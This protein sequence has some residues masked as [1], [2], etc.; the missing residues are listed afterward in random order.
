MSKT[1]NKNKTI[2]IALIIGILLCAF[3]LT[4]IILKFTVLDFF[5]NLTKPYLETAYEEA[6]KLFITLSLLKGTTDVIEGS[7][8]NVN[9]ILGM[10]IQIGDMVQPIY[11]IVDI[12]WKISLASVVVLKLE[13]IYYEIFKVKLASALVFISL[14]SYFPYTFFKNSVTEILKKIS[15]Y[16]LLA[17]IFIYVLLPGTIFLS[18]G[19]SDY[20]EKEYK[21]PAVT[22]LNQSLDNLNK[23]KDDLFVLEQSK[24]LFNIPGQIEST[25]NKFSNLSQEIGNVSKDL[26]DYTPVIIG[27]TLMSYIIL[28]LLLLIFLYKLTKSILLEKINK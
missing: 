16:A 28:P 14:I 12:L 8:V 2:K 13:T 3:G 7:T 9:V 1:L 11:D 22:R 10:N 27:I 26:A 24:G 6:K 25:K 20:F 4:D 21:R 18:S 5:K 23:V 15:K 19:I 17:F